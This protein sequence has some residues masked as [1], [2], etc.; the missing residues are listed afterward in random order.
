[1]RAIHSET[2]NNVVRAISDHTKAS[3]TG[4]VI[5]VTH[6][7]LMQS[8]YWHHRKDWHLIIDEAPQVFY[9]AEFTL[10]V[11]HDDLLPGLE[12]EPYNVRYSRLVPGDA[13]L[14]EDIATNRRGDQVHALFQEFAA[15]LASNRWDLFVLNEQWERFQTGQITDGKLLVFGLIDPMVLD[16]FSTTTIMSANLEC[17]AAYRYL[18]QCG[19]TFQPHKAIASKLRFTSHANGDL[20]AIHYA[21]EDGNWSKH[22]RDRQIELAGDSYSVNELIICGALDLFGDEQFVWLANKDIE[23]KDPFGGRGI[24]LPH[25]PHGLNSF[26][27]VHNAAVL[28]ALNPSPALYAFLD[29]VAHLN[30]D[31]VRRA[32]YHEAAYQAAGRISTRNLAD[33]TPK[34]VVVADR[35]AA[36]ALA[37][38]YPGAD[39]VRLPFASLIPGSAKAGR[40]RVHASDAACNAAYRDRRKTDLL[41]QLDSVN[42]TM[43]ERKLPYTY[44][45]ISSRTD[46]KFGGSV[47]ADIYSKLALDQASALAVGDF[48]AWLRDL[49]DRIIPKNDAFLWSPAEFDP[50]MASDT[51]RGLANIK[52][53]WGIWLD[54]DG[55]DLRPDEFAAM[56]PYLTLVMYNSAS[57]TKVAPRWRAVIP[58]TCAMTIEVH[59]DILMQLMKTLNRRGYYSKKQLEKRAQRGLGGKLHGFDPS[60]FAACSLFYLPVQA[61]AGRDASFFMTFDGGRRQAINPYEWINK[62]IIDHR[63]EPEP[64]PAQKVRRSMPVTD[65]PRL[66]RMRELIAE[67]E[68]AGALSYRVRRRSAAIEKWRYA[69]PGDGNGAFFQLGVDLD[70]AGMSPA[71][72][73]A[74]LQ[75]EA[76]YARH[77]S[78]RLTQIRYIIRSLPGSFC[79][80]AA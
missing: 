44:K 62:T 3:T 14:L 42:E 60:K 21:I 23:D 34:H 78:E 74:I 53:I 22:K 28:A 2:T 40:R 4:E 69:S 11:N 35:Y 49:H 72:I 43:C 46:G 66:R 70:R 59:R 5:F 15:K 80:L 29:E 61:A 31:E 24:R 37:E 41:A 52:A 1:M 67:E 32:V 54:C 20:L 58:T 73:D 75:Q 9:Q 68:V 47:F 64:E 27:H 17:T 6:A 39:V 63:P 51:S 79:R 77:P 38:L 57:S 56:F 45:D 30:S 19:H 18:V 25:T 65:C 10:P 50:D 36:E 55:G 33:Q 26:Q 48:V 16:G 7:A 71:E 12:A 13:A 8:V 76:G